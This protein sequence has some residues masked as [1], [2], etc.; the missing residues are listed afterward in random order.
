MIKAG[1]ILWNT[2]LIDLSVHT[3]KA[4]QML[5][6][7][8]KDAFSQPQLIPSPVWC[9]ITVYKF[10]V[11]ASM[12]TLYLLEFVLKITALPDNINIMEFAMHYLPIA[13][14][15]LLYWDVQSVSIPLTKLS[16]KLA[17]ES[18]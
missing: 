12:A 6:T 2:Q 5:L 9:L 13:S 17:L 14:L 7:S 4:T 3:I 8:M 1:P 15:T 10:A 18:P 11:N 16:T